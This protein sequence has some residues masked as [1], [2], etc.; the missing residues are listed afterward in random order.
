MVPACPI[1]HMKL[2]FHILLFC[3][4]LRINKNLLIAIIERHYD[5]FDAMQN[6]LAQFNEDGEHYGEKACI[7]EV[8]RR[9]VAQN[10]E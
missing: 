1:L 5:R 10:V 4:I 2:A 6:Y 9:V 8:L 3:I 7:P